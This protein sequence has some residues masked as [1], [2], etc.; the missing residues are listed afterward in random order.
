MKLQ[1]AVEYQNHPLAPPIRFVVTSFQPRDV[2]RYTAAVTVALG[3]GSVPGDRVAVSTALKLP[4]SVDTAS[5]RR[6][7]WAAAPR[8]ELANGSTAA[9]G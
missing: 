9:A 5:W 1:T 7:G 3:P 6:W 4:V 2:C 8:A